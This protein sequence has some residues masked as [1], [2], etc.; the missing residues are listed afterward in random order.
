GVKLDGWFA[1]SAVTFPVGE[2]D[3]ET[4]TLLDVTREALDDGIRE[5]RPGN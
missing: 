1:D 4:R 2:V 3:E 5:A